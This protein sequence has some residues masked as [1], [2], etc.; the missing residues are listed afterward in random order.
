LDP[1]EA[2][3]DDETRISE[4]TILPDGRI[5]VFGMSREL[6]EI[7]DGW[8]LGDADIRQRIDH[9]RACPRADS[10]RCEGGSARV[11]EVRSAEAGRLGQGESQP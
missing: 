5:C 7:L 1:D 9:V 6:L 2:M 8:N 10:R 11:G 3:A 4:I